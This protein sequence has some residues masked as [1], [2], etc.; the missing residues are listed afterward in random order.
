MYGTIITDVI[1]SQYNP[2]VVA[3]M[4]FPLFTPKSTYSDRAIV[5]LFVAEALHLAEI[6]R[7]TVEE[8]MK[9]NLDQI[10]LHHKAYGISESF[11]N[12][13]NNSLYDN[14]DF[15]TAHY[16]YPCG[17]SASS[18]EE[19]LQLSKICAEFFN[20]NPVSI[21]RAQLMAALVY[22]IKSNKMKRWMLQYHQILREEMR[23][24]VFKQAVIL[25]ES[26]EN[27]IEYTIRWALAHDANKEVAMICGVL[28]FVYARTQLYLVANPNEDELST[29]MMKATD[30]IPLDS[31][32]LARQLRHDWVPYREVEE[33][34]EKEYG[35]T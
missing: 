4:T 21:N 33:I 32:I 35:S 20:K 7:G 1:L 3:P 13:I 15:S 29:L 19:A 16:C 6:G 10:N 17:L 12:Q 9:R 24:S 23:D 5:P 8:L 31:Q 25:M 11:I 30:Y 26:P 2:L 14:A 27:G 28:A 22:L 34:W 18:L